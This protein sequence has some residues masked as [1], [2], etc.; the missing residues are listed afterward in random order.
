VEGA[1]SVAVGD[2]NGDGKP[3]VAVV[4]GD[5]VDVLLGNGDGSLTPYVAYP[6]TNPGNIAVGS[7]RGNGQLDLVIACSDATVRVLLGNGDGTFQPQAAYGAV[8]AF[9][10]YYGA[11]IVG[12]F[13]GDG[14]MDVAFVNDGTNLAG[15]LLGNGDGTFG[16]EL[17][18]G[19][20][21]QPK[22]LTAGDFNGDGKL[23]LA[24]EDFES[25]VGVL[26]GNGD[27]TFRARPDYPVQG[28][29]TGVTI[30]D[31]NGDG[32]PDLAV[33]ALC[34]YV[35]SPCISRTVDIFLGNPDGT[36][37]V[38]A[39]YAVQDILSGSWLV[40]ASSI[41]AT[42]LNH[43]GKLDL[44]VGNFQEIDGSN[45][46]LGISVLLG[47]GDGTFQTHTDYAG[48]SLVQDVGSPS[49][50]ASVAAADFNGDGNPD[51][52]ATGPQLGAVVWLGN[53][54]GSFR[55][56]V[57]YSNTGGGSSALAVGDFN[58]DGIPDLAVTNGSQTFTWINQDEGGWSYAGTTVSVL[59]G[60][61][62]GSFGPPVAYGTA[63]DPESVAVGDVNG[64]GKLDLVVVAWGEASYSP[65]GGYL[66]ILL[67]NGDGTFQKH[68][69]FPIN[70]GDQTLALAVGDF[71]LDGK[72][73]VVVGSGGSGVGLLLG[74]GDG[75]FQSET[76]YATGPGPYMMAIGDFNH[77]GKPDLATSDYGTVSVLRNIQGPD[78]SV[79]AAGV[80][81]ITRGQ[82]ASSTV[83]ITSILGYSNSVALSCAVSLTSGT[84]TAPTCSVSPASV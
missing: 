41:V 14:R 77:D 16:A 47:N 49:E 13:N 48:A 67:G 51:I 38:P 68:R 78:F 74:N 64:D 8:S 81:P 70:G 3:D 4:A 30:G 71:N 45:H 18:F 31:F 29:A 9:G 58:G 46:V 79:Q 53:G 25:S 42:D 50:G 37:G 2:F 11:P 55:T 63:N 26:L 61:G 6:V 72:L 57:Q 22:S 69:D 19:T 43:D 54:D 17:L 73:D 66:S 33:A 23:D 52:V 59:L 82:S 36:F 65:T 83:T 15:V 60:K 56:S 39:T 84:G 1:N 20:G 34:D 76:T 32:N 44:V 24:T 40:G 80:S 28:A 62:D 35:D 10:F 27:G 5:S 21:S 12:D 75:T 7:L